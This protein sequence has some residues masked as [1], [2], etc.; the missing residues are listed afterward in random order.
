METGKKILFFFFVL[1][2]ISS[3]VL[4]VYGSVQ[5]IHT[6][7]IYYVGD[8]LIKFSGMVEESVTGLITIVIHDSNNE[9]VLL[10]QI[11]PQPDDSYELVIDT[12]S[13]FLSEGTY[14]VTAFVTNM[15][16][17]ASILFDY[18]F[19]KASIPSS[20]ITS[21][22]SDEVVEVEDIDTGINSDE[23][24]ESENQITII[25]GFPDPEKDPQYYVNR[26]EN[27]PKYREWFD[28]YFPDKT[29]YEVVGLEN[30]SETE[31]LSNQDTSLSN[32]SE[33][34]FE[35]ITDEQIIMQSTFATTTDSELS[36]IFF[37]IGGL[38][39][40]FGAVYGIKRRV[41]GNSVQIA[42]NKVGI[43]K[44]VNSNCNDPLEFLKNRLVQG[45]ISIRQYK[46]LRKAL[47]STN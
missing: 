20:L 13:K 15:T 28:Y 45:E 1:V 37:A 43:E 6:D 36:Q 29:I 40:L 47:E 42:K 46:K 24:L 26:Y 30:K 10:R 8:D 23:T 31:D 18:Y 38:G 9:F 19:Y 39:V 2:L 12:K 34:A 7:K 16:K 5:T 41:D 14:N 21:T 33:N 17:G 3:T 11:F 25:P 32:S 4:P 44:K 27:E 22:V 35:S